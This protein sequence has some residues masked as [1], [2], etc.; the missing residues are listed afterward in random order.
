MSRWPGLNS[1]ISHTGTRWK[2]DVGGQEFFHERTTVGT[3]KVTAWGIALSVQFL[4]GLLTAA[5]QAGGKEAI[6]A[7]KPRL[8]SGKMRRQCAQFAVFVQDFG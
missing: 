2:R 5:Q 6:E 7:G 1:S 8:G 4:S 3:L